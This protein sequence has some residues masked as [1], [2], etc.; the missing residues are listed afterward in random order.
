MLNSGVRS[1]EENDKRQI[2]S[3]AKTELPNKVTLAGGNG[4]YPDAGFR[5]LAN[6]FGTAR[7][8][9]AGR[10]W[11]IFGSQRILRQRCIF[12]P[13]G[14]GRTSRYGLCQSQR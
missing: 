7:R 8:G 11:R 5:L 2:R 14:P 13:T 6:S 12:A 1:R 3:S 4:E 10:K 9:E